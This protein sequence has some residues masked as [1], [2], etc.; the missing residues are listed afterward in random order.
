M[1]CILTWINRSTLHSEVQ[2]KF[3]AMKQLVGLLFFV[4]TIKVAISD[5]EISSP[6]D[7][8]MTDYAYGG[9]NI[10][11]SGKYNVKDSAALCQ[12]SCQVPLYSGL[13]L[14][15]CLKDLFRLS[16]AITSCT[17][18]SFYESDGKC[19]LKSGGGNG[20]PLPGVISGPR[21]C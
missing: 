2:P 7:C 12:Q 16:Q 6:Q 19:E 13:W 1:L 17:F 18:F 15:S 10:L 5:L 11:V 14:N 21:N 9:D 4:L 8:F 3:Q 20:L